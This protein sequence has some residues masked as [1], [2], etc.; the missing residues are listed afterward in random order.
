MKRNKIQKG[1]P[2]KLTIYQH[3][4]P[5]ACIARFGNKDGFVDTYL[6]KDKKKIP[7][8][9]KNPLFC[10]E[11]AWD[12]KSEKGY[13][14]DIE[15]PYNNFAQSILSGEITLLNIDNHK[16]ISDMFALWCVRSYYKLNST[17]DKK[18][19]GII[20]VARHITQ[21]SQES[22]EKHG[23]ITITPDGYIRGPQIVG[24]RIVIEVSILQE[25]LSDPL[26]GI[27]RARE[28]EFIVPDNP[29][30][31]EGPSSPQSF[32]LPLSPSICF[33]YGWPNQEILFIEV[34]QINMIA[35][36]N[37]RD[38]YFGRDLSRYI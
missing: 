18:L 1:N 35:R 33:I 34:N 4:F 13:I 31:I 27:V 28:G 20:G 2:H 12:Q 19:N 11:K 30:Y 25:K 21:D 36:S 23:V 37:S 9:P 7:L 16:I 17:K 38:Y 22:L 26:W 8:D 15:K 6:I 24:P 32:I 10:A 14:E 29:G 3:T 5:R